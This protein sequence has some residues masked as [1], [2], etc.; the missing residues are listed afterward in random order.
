VPLAWLKDDNE[1]WYNSKLNENKNMSDYVD[2]Y[3][4]IYALKK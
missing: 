1:N 2:A 3:Y 4:I